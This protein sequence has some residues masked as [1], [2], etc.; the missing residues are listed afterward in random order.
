MAGQKFFELLK[1]ISKN[2]RKAQR[3]LKPDYVDY[4]LFN[5]RLATA[6]YAIT[7]ALSVMGRYVDIKER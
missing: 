1:K 4:H 7:E 6:D 5:D 3:G 2:I